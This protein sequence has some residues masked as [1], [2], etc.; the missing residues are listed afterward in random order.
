MSLVPADY[1]DRLFDPI[2]RCLTRDGAKR[3]LELELDP[4]VRQ[5]LDELAAKSQAGTLTDEEFAEYDNYVNVI[6]FIGILQSKAN[7]LVG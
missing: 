4:A 3:L 5:R 6:D 1:I 7:A 2:A